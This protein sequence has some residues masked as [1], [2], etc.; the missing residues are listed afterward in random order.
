VH[1]GRHRTRQRTSDPYGSY[2]VAASSS[3]RTYIYFFNSRG[4]RTA[5]GRQEKRTGRKTTPPL[6]VCSVSSL[7]LRLRERDVTRLNDV[8]YD[9]SLD[10]SFYVSKDTSQDWVTHTH[11][12]CS[13]IYVII[14]CLVTCCVVVFVISSSESTFLTLFLFFCLAQE[15][16][17][18]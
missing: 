13:G 16:R 1:A 15:S 4:S 3:S 9:V 18:A 8:S 14:S 11:T 12:F 17:I 6:D 10:M 5:E 2:E 7:P